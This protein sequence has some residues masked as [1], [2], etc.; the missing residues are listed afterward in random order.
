MADPATKPARTKASFSRAG[1]G[2][3]VL[4]QSLCVLFLVIAA[5]YVGFNYFQRW[6]FSRSQRFTLAEQTKQALKQFQPA[7]KMT[8]YFSPTNLGLE[9]GL[10]GDVQNLLA[11]LQFSARQK[12]EVEWVDPVR[13]VTRA[14]ELQ[15]KYKF[16]GTQSV[17]VLDY[18]GRVKV[19]PIIEMGDY[20]LSGVANGEPAQL[21]AFIGE[22]TLT[23]AFVELLNPE[24]A[25]VYFLQGHDEAKREDLNGLCE[26]ITR[27][28][29]E[30]WGL[31]LAA[32]NGI[33]K[34]AGAVCLIGP[35]FDLSAAELKILEG[36]WRQNGRLVILVDPARMYGTPNL[37]K[38]INSACIYPRNDRV[39]RILQNRL[40]PGVIGVDKDVVGVFLPSSVITK[41]LTGVNAFFAGGTLSLLLDVAGAPR[42]DIQLRPLVQATEEYWGEARY[43]D[44]TTAGVRFDQGEDAGQ[45]V[46]LAA[47]AEKGGSSDD[48]TDVATSRMVVVGNSAFIEDRT[49][50]AGGPGNLDFMISALNRMLERKS[51]LG[52]TPRVVT[53]YMLNLTDP[54]LSG[55]ALYALTG[56]PGLAALLGIFVAIRRRA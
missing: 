50:A 20:D 26:A 14:R 40:N 5:N 39:L 15:E 51:L 54:Q 41:R 32:S 3:G 16:D 6:D 31:N 35:K 49:L 13:D 34:D 18:G 48:R 47:Y 43:A 2:F 55:I 45:P 1:I 8:V 25:R 11:E 53:N 27:Q 21:R 44:V 30:V 10:Y 17:I 24:R 33:P 52:V 42:A 46:I 36:Y 28:N 23:T 56:L 37:R 9:S 29:A 22:A 38:L 12:L 4:V 19:V 7:L